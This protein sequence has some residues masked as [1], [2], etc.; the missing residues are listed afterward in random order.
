MSRK[1]LSRRSWTES[2]NLWITVVVL[3]ELAKWLVM[4]QIVGSFSHGTVIVL[5]DGVSFT[6]GAS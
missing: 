4:L 3:I 2:D 5:T 1:G 6:S